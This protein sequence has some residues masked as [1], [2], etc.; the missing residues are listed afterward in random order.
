MTNRALSPKILF[1][2]LDGT[3]LDDRKEIGAENRAAIHRALLA[4]H[5]IV[6]T[7]GRALSSAA[8]LCEELRLTSKGCYAICFNGAVIYDS[9]EK[10]V[11]FERTLSHTFVRRLFDEAKQANL[12]I[13]TYAG[14]DVLCENPSKNLDEYIAQVHMGKKIVPDVIRELGSQEPPKVLMIGEHDQLEAFRLSSFSWREG[15]IDSLFSCPRYLEFIPHGVSKG[16]SLK[17]LCDLLGFPLSCTIAAGD[18][19]NDLSMIQAAHTGVVMANASEEMK[20]CA[21]YVTTR[22]NNHGGIAEII[23]RF[24]LCR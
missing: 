7:T 14:T 21:D 11:I 19:E 15:K 4:G 8:K 13:Q 22:D 16:N 24:M 3:L 18:A 12:H 23:E 5:K 10:K 2:D 17:I 20:S 1:T 6:I 9:Y